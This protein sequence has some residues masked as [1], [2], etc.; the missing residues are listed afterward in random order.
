MRSLTLVTL[1]ICSLS[2]FFAAYGLSIG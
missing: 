2:I 1:Y